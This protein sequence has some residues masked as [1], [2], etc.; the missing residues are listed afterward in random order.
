M[1]GLVVGVWIQSASWR[2]ASVVAQ[3]Q[4]P[5]GV[6][7]AVGGVVEA[8]TRERESQAGH[9][10]NV[11]HGLPHFWRAPSFLLHVWFADIVQ[12]VAGVRGMGVVAAKVDSENCR[13]QVPVDIMMW[14]RAPCA[15]Y[16]TTS[17]APN[18]LHSAR[19]G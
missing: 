14:R 15:S 17:S 6:G 10:R 2:I 1:R 12:W 4:G 9:K 8:S 16:C 7:N 18:S 13:Q 19:S 5:R 3:P 11:G